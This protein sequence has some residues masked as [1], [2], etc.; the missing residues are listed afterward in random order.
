MTSLSGTFGILA[1][2]EFVAPNFT[3]SDSIFGSG[4]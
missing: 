4:R 2:Y 3:G 1:M